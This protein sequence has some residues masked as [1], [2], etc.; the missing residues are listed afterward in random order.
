[1]WHKLL[2]GPEADKPSFALSLT[3]KEPHI[4]YRT[5]L[6]VPEIPVWAALPTDHSWLSYA[7]LV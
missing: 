4:L 1:M 5:C 3:L 6:G 2:F 7:L